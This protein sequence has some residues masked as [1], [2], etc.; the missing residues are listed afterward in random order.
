MKSGDRVVQIEFE[1]F[2]GA[3]FTVPVRDSRT[4]DDGQFIGELMYKCAKAVWYRRNEA[5]RKRILESQTAEE[6]VSE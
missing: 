6:A 1:E 4:K 5:D 2:P 3:V